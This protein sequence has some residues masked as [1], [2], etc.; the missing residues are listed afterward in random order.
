M[1]IW[2]IRQ[3]VYFIHDPTSGVVNALIAAIQQD[4]QIDISSGPVEIGFSNDLTIHDL[5][6]SVFH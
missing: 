2:S 3:M 5:R 6:S 1:V 4:L